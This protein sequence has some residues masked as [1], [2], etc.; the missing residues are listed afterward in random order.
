MHLRINLEP[1]NVNGSTN[2]HIAAPRR[3]TKFDIAR[4]MTAQ[5]LCGTTPRHLNGAALRQHDGVIG[6][7]IRP[8]ERCR[9]SA[10]KAAFRRHSRKSKWI[11]DR[12]RW[13]RLGPPRL[14]SPRLRSRRPWREHRANHTSS[15]GR[16]A[17]PAWRRRTGL[18]G[19]TRCTGAMPRRWRRCALE[20]N[21][22]DPASSP[23]GEVVM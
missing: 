10:A 5:E 18:R 4:V 20:E 2:L 21:Y 13:T 22:G 16:S 8:F 9:G 7:G 17:S 15:A 6:R 11:A 12:V 3:C 23:V 19:R 1:Y 14:C